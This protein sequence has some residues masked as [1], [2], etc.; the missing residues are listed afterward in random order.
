MFQTINIV[1]YMGPGQRAEACLYHR[2]LDSHVH[3]FGQT[4]SCAASYLGDL[5]TES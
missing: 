2:Y 3:K 5:V 4:S 1:H